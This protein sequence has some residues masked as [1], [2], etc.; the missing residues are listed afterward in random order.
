MITDNKI[1]DNIIIII[2][3]KI[4]KV[5]TQCL[6]FSVHSNTSGYSQYHDISVDNYCNII[7]S[8]LPCVFLTLPYAASCCVITRA[9]SGY[10]CCTAGQ[11]ERKY[12]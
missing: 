9:L 4:S 1:T 3:I 8:T 7:F 11:V 5:I 10:G 6:C 2:T 12:I